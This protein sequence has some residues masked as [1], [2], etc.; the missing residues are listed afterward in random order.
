MLEHIHIKNII[1][2]DELSIDCD[3]GF[4]A[5][6]GETGAGKSIWID[7]ICLVRLI[8]RLLASSIDSLTNL[9]FSV[10]DAIFKISK[11]I[12]NSLINKLMIYICFNE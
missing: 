4:S 12:Y 11:S 1:V 3:A 10:F 7:A 8:D 2:V 6:T 9:L 5:I